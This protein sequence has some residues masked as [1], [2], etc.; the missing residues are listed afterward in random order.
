[1]FHYMIVSNVILVGLVGMHK[2]G[3]FGEQSLVLH[4]PSHRELESV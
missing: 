1:M 4:V 3:C 2:T